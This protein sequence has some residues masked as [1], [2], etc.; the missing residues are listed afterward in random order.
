MCICV[1]VSVSMCVYMCMRDPVHAHVL[2]CGHWMVKPSSFL[3]P[4]PHT[5]SPCNESLQFRVVNGK[6]DMVKF[7]AGF[8]H[9]LLGE[10]DKGNNVLFLS[11]N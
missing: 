6:E 4:F 11:T 8:I 9:F 7:G 5:I 1:C 2:M 10:E 3:M